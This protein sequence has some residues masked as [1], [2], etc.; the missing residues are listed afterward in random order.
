M[1]EKTKY[2][3]VLEYLILTYRT[4]L[5][6]IPPGNVSLRYKCLQCKSVKLPMNDIFAFVSYLLKSLSNRNKY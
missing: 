6:A 2:S 5:N 1:Y 3:K 4:Y